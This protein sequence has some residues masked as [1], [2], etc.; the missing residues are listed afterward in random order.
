MRSAAG[1]PWQ[2]L[3]P[4]C[5]PKGGARLAAAR[6]GAAR[7]CFARELAAANDERDLDVAAIALDGLLLRM[8]SAWYAA[9]GW[10][11]FGAGDL[12][13]DLERRAPELAWRLRLALRAPDAAARL[14]HARQVLAALS[15]ALGVAPEAGPDEPPVGLSV[16]FHAMRAGG[17]PGIGTSDRAQKEAIHDVR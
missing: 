14:A 6:F 7:A 15:A 5:V 16:P 10:P 12:L 4:S 9:C 13:L 2:E 11:P 1:E 17:R 3:V 8:L